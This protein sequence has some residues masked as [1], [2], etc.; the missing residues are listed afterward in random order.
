[1]IEKRNAAFIASRAMR[2]LS[3]NTDLTFFGQGSIV[4]TIIDSMANEIEALYDSIDIN[5]SQTKL[6]TA[7]GVF[8][9]LIAAQFGITRSPGNS[10]TILAE[11]KVVRFF[12]NKGR[13]MDYLPGSTPTNGTIPSGTLIY[14]ADGNTTYTVS[15]SV[16]FSASASSVWVPVAPQDTSK[17]S[18]N[19]VQAGSLRSHSLNSSQIFVENVTSIVTGTDP[20]TDEELRL[21]ISRVVNSSVTGSKSAVLQAAFSFPGISD[22]KISNNKYGAGSFEILLVPSTA[23]LPQNVI[24]RVRAAV[25]DV[26]P[27][28]I[29]AEIRGPEIVSVSLVIT[30]DIKSGLLSQVKD[31]AVRK[32]REAVTNYI[33]NIPMG[34]ELVINRIRA[35]A[36]DVHE[37]IRDI[38]IKQLAIDCRPQVIANYRLRSD[39]I[40][41]IDRKLREPIM[42]L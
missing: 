42:V 34:G 19:N 28:G 41:D 40:F 5:L 29:R 24:E 25:N 23:R 10:G 27:F 9:D 11:D 30:I 18:A 32:V 37:S 20:E 22:I 36:L 31:T 13:L 8:L 12:V 4:K 26:I 39:E 33:A 1:M 35:L 3:A 38:D 7:S 16:T 2:N 21:R 6:S 15:E 17:G 14:S